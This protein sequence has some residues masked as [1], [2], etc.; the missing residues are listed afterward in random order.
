MSNN[1]NT[2]Q[3]WN[4]QSSYGSTFLS[5]IT[6]NDFIK[7][8]NTPEHSG[9]SQSYNTYPEILGLLTQKLIQYNN[10][11]FFLL[12]LNSKTSVGKE[13]KLEGAKS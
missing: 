6:K 1:T 4:Y 7:G 2:N 10:H 5:N 8:L 9:R 12:N 13:L 3:K 11:K